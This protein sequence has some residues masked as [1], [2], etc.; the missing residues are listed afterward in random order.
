MNDGLP[1]FDESFSGSTGEGAERRRDPR[2]PISAYTEIE[3][4]SPVV[5]R[6]SGIVHDVSRSGL[7]LGIPCAVDEHTHVKIN[8]DHLV[9]QG[10]IR[11][12]RPTDNGFHAGVLVQEVTGPAQYDELDDAELDLF[13]ILAQVA[14]LAK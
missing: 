3:I 11:Y 1:R 10:E 9:I 7:R 12:C 13:G 2:F 14:L 4:Q 8:L 6:V 5:Q